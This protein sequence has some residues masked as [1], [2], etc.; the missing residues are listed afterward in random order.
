MAEMLARPAGLE[1]ATPSL[2]GLGL[3]LRTAEVCGSAQRGDEN[4]T[5]TK[6]IATRVAPELHRRPQPPFSRLSSSRSTASRM[7]A[8]IDC[9]P[10]A[11]VIRARI[12][13]SKRTIVA[14]VSSALDPSG[15]RPMRDPLSDIV[16][17]AKCIMFPVS[18]IDSQ[19]DAAYP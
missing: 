18:V 13:A 5:G 19:S 14:F 17:S 16:L 12:S 11:A 1:P 10:F 2:E 4:S 7:K 8:P 9:V 15:G 6:G 3:E